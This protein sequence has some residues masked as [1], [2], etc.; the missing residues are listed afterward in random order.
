MCGFLGIRRFDGAPVDPRALQELA[1]LLAHRGPD[2]DGVWATGSV[3]FAHRRLAIIDPHGPAQPMASTD[4]LAHVAFNGE[5][6]NYR[7]LRATL[8]YPFRTDG[9]T[10]VLLALH[11]ERGPVGVEELRGQFAYALHDATDDVTW[12]VRDR[13]GILPLFYVQTE[14]Y[15]AFASEAKALLPLVPGGAQVDEEALDAYLSRRAVPAP[16]TLYRGIRKL[17]P[18]HVARIDPDGSMALRSY[19]SLPDAASV[20]EVTDADAVE[21]V[22][23]GLEQAVDACLVADVPVGTYLSG[24]LDSSLI[25]AL[26]AARWGSGVPTFSVGFGDARLDELPHARVVS[27]HLRTEHTEVR[28][29][30]EDFSDAWQQLTWHRDAPLSEPADLAVHRLA[31]AA[32]EHVK[33]VL[34]GEGSDELFGGYPKHR[35]ARATVAAGAVPPSLRRLAARAAERLPATGTTRRLAIAGRALAEVTE[36]ERIQAW[37]APFTSAERRALLGPTAEPSARGVSDRAGD[38]LRRMLAADAGPWLADNLLERGDRMTMAASVELR[39][40]FLDHRLVELAF[41][42]PSSVKVRRGAGKWV[43]K[44]VARPLLPASIVDRPKSGFPVPL[45]AWFRGDLRSMA[46]DR[47]LA[48]S[49]FVTSVFDRAGVRALLERHDRGR[50]DE[51]IRIWTLLGLEIWHD[52]CIAGASAPSGAVA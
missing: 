20:E 43:V 10:E 34:S 36:E 44:E 30:A 4:G 50:R 31:A 16:R 40:P 27:E 3:G 37:F 8:R 26:V 21:Q 18:G 14:A 51:A 29:G 13:L 42:L 47:L 48:P 24:G 35:F 32:G 46:W 33:V 39:P 17:L 45:D 41:R 6:L 5:I 12:L 7:E 25:T 19:W 23:T 1:G 15:V 49:S 38:P 22:R 9:D 52:A 28:V 2:G 11:R